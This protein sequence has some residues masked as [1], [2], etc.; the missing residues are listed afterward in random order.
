[1]RA[2]LLREYKVKQIYLYKNKVI[3]SLKTMIQCFKN[4]VNIYI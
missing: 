1:M 4:K 2:I 3:M